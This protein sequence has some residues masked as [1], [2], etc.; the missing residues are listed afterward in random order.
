MAIP[1]YGAAPLAKTFVLVRGLSLISM[2]TIVGLTANFV[3]Q[4]VS[5]NVEAP[6]EIIGTLAIVGFTPNNRAVAV[7]A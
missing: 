2:V 5:S 7:H 3:S 4:I 1:E 6:K